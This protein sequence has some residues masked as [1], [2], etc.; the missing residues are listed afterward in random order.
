M[1][2]SDPSRSSGTESFPVAGGDRSLSDMYEGDSVATI[3]P[4]SRDA[5]AAALEAERQRTLQLIAPLSDEAL[6]RQHDPLMSPMVWDLGHIG[7]FEELWLVRR[8]GEVTS[9]SELEEVYDAFRTPRSAR[10]ELALP[11]V[12]RVTER[13]AEIRARALELL[14]TVEF[15]ADNPLLRGGF[16]WEMV[17][18][19]EAQHQETMLQTIQLVT[20]EAYVPVERRGPPAGDAAGASAATV[21]EMVRVPGGPFAIGAPQGAFAYD[22]ER[23]RHRRVV[24]AFEIGR[25]PVTNGEYVEF[26]AAGGYEDPALW[27]EEGWTW[28][29]KARLAAPQFWELAAH[30]GPPSAPDA[31][32]A[33]RE[34]GLAG[35]HRRTALGVEPLRPDAPVVHVCCH[36][37]EAYARFSSARLPTEME[38]EKAA[39]WDPDDGRSRRW[40]WGEAP[41]SADLANLDQLRFGVDPVG[42]R[43]AGRSAVGCEEMIGD[44]WEWTST[45]F[46]GYDGFRAFPYPEYS[47]VFFG[48]DYR[49]LRGASWATRPAVARNTFRNWD[50]PIRRQIFSGFR[51][52]RDV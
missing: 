47:E 23:P 34:L 31:R 20:S 51:L 32:A 22:N 26:V 18:Q 11:A 4:P 21:G 1:Y 49:V 19:H 42:A 29:Q 9:E 43:P 17:R 16:A 13:M 5:I 50:Y 28:A 33:S 8:P 46:Y 15:E 52:A 41:L 14:E 2:P 24:G 48:P 44:V 7:A 40:P 38:W 12:R 3:P 25:H 27:S 30:P 35:W 39:A 36:E 6:T 37:A 45:R 10:G